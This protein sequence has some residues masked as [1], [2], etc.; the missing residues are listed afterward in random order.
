MLLVKGIIIM[1]REQG[2]GYKTTETDPQ[3]G[4][5]EKVDK[6]KRAAGL[7]ENPEDWREQK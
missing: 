2:E 4:T 3:T 5:V 6:Q 7:A 1:E